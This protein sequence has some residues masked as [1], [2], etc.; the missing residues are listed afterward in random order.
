MAKLALLVAIENVAVG[1]IAC[2]AVTSFYRASYAVGSLAS[3][4]CTGLGGRVK[5]IT[6][7][8]VFADVVYDFFTLCADF[9]EQRGSGF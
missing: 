5:V 8:T 7:R 4:S 3:A 2:T 6:E 1:G 9:C